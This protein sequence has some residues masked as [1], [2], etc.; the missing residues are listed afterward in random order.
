M[1]LF[2]ITFFIGLHGDMAEGLL[3]SAFIEEGYSMDNTGEHKLMI[4]E[5]IM[6]DVYDDDMKEIYN[7]KKINDLLFWYKTHPFYQ[8]IFLYSFYKI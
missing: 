7:N 4:P 2:T 6:K 3:I 1:S 8:F 5:Q